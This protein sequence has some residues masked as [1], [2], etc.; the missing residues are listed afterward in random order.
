MPLTDA[1][2]LISAYFYF[3][4]FI[5]LLTCADVVQSKFN[6]MQNPSSHKKCTKCSNDFNFIVFK[7]SVERNF[8]FI[9]KE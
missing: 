8:Y 4:L 2:H 5:R 3:A 6:N 7:K 1:Q 9:F